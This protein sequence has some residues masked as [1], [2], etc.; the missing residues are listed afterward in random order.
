MQQSGWIP[1]VLLSQDE[2]ATPWHK[3]SYIQVLEIKAVLLSPLKKE[4]V[5]FSAI[6]ASTDVSSR[7]SL[8]CIGAKRNLSNPAGS[9][10]VLPLRLQP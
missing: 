4:N 10:R 1:P 2:G 8:S 7:K 3:L 6:A 5:Y 9:K